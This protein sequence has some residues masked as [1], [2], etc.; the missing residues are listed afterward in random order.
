MTNRKAIL[1]IGTMKTGTSSIQ[2]TLRK[3]PSWLAQRGWEFGAGAQRTSESIA[4]CIHSIKDGR[5]LII[6]D[7]GLW[8]FAKSDRSD[9][10]AIA[11]LLRDEGF[12]VK[13]L[14]YFR[15]PDAFL[16][17]WYIQGLKNGLG[18]ASFVEFEQSVFARAGCNFYGR[19][20]IFTDLF[21]KGAIQIA[22]YEKAQL[23]QGDVVTDFLVRCGLAGADDT[24][25]SLAAS[26]L[27]FPPKQNVSPDAN[28]IL[29]V[30]LLR[31]LGH[32]P[33]DALKQA[34]KAVPLVPSEGAGRI[35]TPQEVKEINARYLPVFRRLQAQ[36]GGGAAPDF[37][38]DWSTKNES[39]K[40]CVM[41][42]AYD[43]LLNDPVG[44][45]APTVVPPPVSTSAAVA[46]QVTKPQSKTK[47]L[48]VV[49]VIQKL[50]GL[51]GGAERV[52]V[53][54]A[55][56]MRARGMDVRI[57]TFD[58]QPASSLF[59]S[60]VIPMQSLFPLRKATKEMHS[61][62][63]GVR[64]LKALPNIAPLTHVKW[65]LS[66][67]M[68]IRALRA[69]LLARP[70]DVVVA[71]LP[72][73]IT[74]TAFAAAGLPTRVVAS[75]HNVPEQD[76]G[77][78]PR[79]DQ[80]PIYRR[81]AREAL[82]RV[83][84]VTVLLPEFRGWFPARVQPN[85]VVLPNAV[86]RLSPE[87]PGVPREKIILGVGRLT[88]V[89][90]WDTLIDAFARVADELPDWQVRIY[91]EGPQDAALRAQISKLG[92]TDRVRLMGVTPRIGAV[93]DR[94]AMVVH[95]SEF[96]G[97]G[98]SVAEAM[99]HGVPAVA[100]ADC[101]GVNT[102]IAD[103]QNGLLVPR[104]RMEVD[105]LAAALVRLGK[106][107]ALRTTLGDAAKQI[108]TRFGAAK[109]Y[110]QWAALLRQVAGK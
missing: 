99:A 48:R 8:H 21:G 95:P 12:S 60:G 78:G 103:G 7:E 67:G 35:L 15:R 89:K 39:T 108:T 24:H 106:D 40:T 72:P 79:W 107:D 53:E 13:V 75:T 22:P 52:F 4:Q 76:F 98:L 56:A 27:I 84:K 62:G 68:F 87:A 64:V 41:R 3:S 38:L 59:G 31:N 91:G 46:S 9:T 102:L 11:G 20:Q 65:R 42:N 14:A 71:F 30:S 49:F 73:A 33:E 77:D 29:L 70:A 32:L 23:A 36:Y 74:A 83:A 5:N 109:I 93:F 86:A 92:L 18:N 45:P 25:E 96:E 6:S 58:T 100:F 101:V 94:A 51:S 82:T 88:G 47:P 54:T 1:H 80:N 90:R 44:R 19:L 2:A 85:L 55:E 57:V 61:A 81:R 63:L 104:S 110:E 28:V 26:G 34:L 105:D 37:F 10:A 97:F 66:H 17:S 16:E 50:T 43:Q 69:D